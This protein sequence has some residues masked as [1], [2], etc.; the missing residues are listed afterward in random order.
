MELDAAQH[1]DRPLLDENGYVRLSASEG[2]N[3]QQDPQ[4]GQKWSAIL[5]MAPGY[6]SNLFLQ[7]RGKDDGKAVYNVFSRIQ[8]QMSTPPPSRKEAPL[9]LEFCFSPDS[10][11]L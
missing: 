6:F 1:P 8:R 3:K 11:K 10:W 4:V 2:A 7:S 9:L 5:E